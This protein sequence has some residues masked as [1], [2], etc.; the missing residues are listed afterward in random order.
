MIH[1][2]LVQ[3]YGEQERLRKQQSAFLGPSMRRNGKWC[4]KNNGVSETSSCRRPASPAGAVNL[5][6]PNTFKS[7]SC[8]CV[9]FHSHG[10]RGM[11]L[12]H[13][14]QVV[15][16]RKKKNYGVRM[17]PRHRT[18]AMT[19]FK[20]TKHSTT[21]DVYSAA[22]VITLSRQLL[23][24]PSKLC[25]TSRVGYLGHETLVCAGTDPHTHRTLLVTHE[26]F[27]LL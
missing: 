12:I 16:A 23:F 18:P 5:R 17:G 7:R 20:E 15:E 11:Q 8:L 14:S 21:L 10:H 26:H 22:F 19:T 1:M 2:G 25:P 9:I 27:S 6:C 4:Q 24:E 13:Y 3:L